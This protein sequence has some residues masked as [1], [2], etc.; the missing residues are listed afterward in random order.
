[1]NLDTYAENPIYKRHIEKWKKYLV[2]EADDDDKLA[3]LEE[4]VMRDLYLSAQLWLYKNFDDVD[5]VWRRDL[6]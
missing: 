4:T 1:L 5:P 6:R 2:E 3:A